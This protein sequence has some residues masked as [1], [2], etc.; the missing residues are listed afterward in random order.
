MPIT[1][2]ASLR[3]HGK[4]YRLEDDTRTHLSSPGSSYGRAAD[5]WQSINILKRNAA[6]AIAEASPMWYLDFEGNGHA[7]P[8]IM[9]TVE[10]IRRVADEALR[11]RRV[12]ARGPGH[13]DGVRP[14]GNPPRAPKV[15]P[16]D[17]SA[18]TRR[19]RSDRDGRDGTW[20]AR[21]RADCAPAA[22]RL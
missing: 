2:V 21:L 6:E 14:A 1:T 12:S 17:S 20:R 15:I 19:A 18:D 11:A 9:R 8:E 3:L 7:N 22:P 5:L 16:R 13:S 4:L 10:Q